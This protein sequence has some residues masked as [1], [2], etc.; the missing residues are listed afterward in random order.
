MSNS[1]PS[2]D[3]A[4]NGS[5]LGSVTFA[6]KKM[7]QAVNHMLPATVINYDRATNRVQVQLSVNLVATDG[8]QIARPQLASI[9]VFVF[10]GGG[11]RLSF[12]LKTGDL[13]WV[14]ANDRDISSFLQ[15]Y[16][17]SAPSSPRLFN[18]SDGV[19]FPDVMTG[20]NTISGADANNVVLQNDT[21][22]ISI[23]LSD[24]EINIIAPIAVNITTPVLAVTG[25]ITATGTITPG[26]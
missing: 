23:S 2:I 9:P 10:G 22:T 6:F 11:F 14:I 13:G 21:A 12:P 4:D 1:N 7:M 15:S 8:S 24:T 19:F 26:V 18:F 25:N 3:P 16:S 5:L 17:Q 20:L